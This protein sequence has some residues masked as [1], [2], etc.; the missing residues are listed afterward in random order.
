MTS[1]KHVETSRVSR[2]HLLIGGAAAG[3]GAVAAIGIDAG[4]RTWQDSNAH[5]GAAS[6]SPTGS[7]VSTVFFGD[8][9]VSPYGAQQAGIISPRPAQAHV[10]LAAFDLLAGV[11]AAAIQ[12][13]LRVL[14]SDI[15]RMTAGD[16]ALADSEPELASRPARLTV[17]IGFGS[18]LV[19]RVNAAAVPA[20]LAPLPAFSRD[21]L[22][23]AYSGGDL[24]VNIQSDDPLTVAHAYR[25]IMR[26]L[27][28]FAAP[29]WVQTGFRRA[30]G[31]E[32]S[33][34]TMRNMMGQ[35]DGTSNP[36]PEVDDFDGL[37]WEPMS[38]GWLAGGSAFVLR[39]IDM[40]L[41]QWDKLP[42]DAREE[43]IGRD[44]AVGAPLTG[45]KETDAPD[46][47]AKDALGRPVIA[48][49]AHIR[50]ASSSDPGERIL[51][52]STNFEENGKA[53]LLFGCYQADPLKQFVPIQRRLDELDLLNQWITHVG[54]AVFAI[55]PGFERGGYLGETLFA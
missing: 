4:V 51:R 10:R 22:T 7:D 8:E 28:T 29:R 33:G 1:E 14:S 43:T 46:F 2:R 3:V 36:N 48:N 49:F 18:E 12:R 47:E 45:S 15:E 16:P 31:A 27:T 26:D 38:A 53:G 54:S 42:R 13:M 40:N 11:D 25:M 5:D 23:D 9:T 55:P 41:D 37:I 44:L 20:W 50:R 19:R 35:V 32:P 17:T 21:Q 52:D 34:T 6:N 30:V 24:L 39:R